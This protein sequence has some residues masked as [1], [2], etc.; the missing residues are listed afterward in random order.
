MK[1]L[2]IDGNSIMNRAFYGI[3]MLTNKS[4]FPTNALTGFLNIYVKLLNEDKPDRIAAAFDL[5]APTFRHKLYCQYKAGRHAM[6][7]ELVRQM[8]VIKDILRGLGISI[9]ETE[10]YEAD[11]II[12]TLSAAAAAQNAECVIMT[13]D[14]DSF[15]LVNEHVTVRLASNKD[16]IYY[17][18]EKINEVYGVTPREM[19]EVKAL[20]GDSSDNIPG[21]AGI[22]EKTALSLIQRYHTIQ[23]IYEHLEELDVTKSVRAKLE[24]GKGSAELSRTL[25]EICLS[26]PISTALDD[27]KPGSGNRSEVVGILRELQMNGAIKKL[28]LEGIAPQFPLNCS[29]LTAASANSSTDAQTAVSTEENAENITSVGSVIVKDEVPYDESAIDIISINDEICAF[30]GCKKIEDDLKSILESDS[31]KHTD[32]AKALYTYCI[33][34]GIE[35]RNVTFDTTLA[36][37][38]LDVNA[39]SYEIDRLFDEYHIAY[40]PDRPNSRILAQT[41]L[42]KTLYAQI[43][44]QG[45]LKVLREIEIPLAEVLA[46]MEHEGVLLDTAALNAFGEDLLP[47]ISE[48]TENVYRLAGH[49]FNIGSPKQLSAVLFSELGLPA[50]KKKSTGYSTDS[51][52]LE[53]IADKHPIIA[54]ILEY[55]RLTKLYN[56]YV[57]GLQGAVS[58]DGRMYT[59]F[60]Q[61]ETRTGRIS[62]AEPNIQNIPV[63]TEIG[64]NFR[65]FFIAA[66]GKVL[67]DADYSQIELR[68]LASLA[69]DEVMIRTFLDNRDIHAETAESVFRKTEG[70]DP[71]DL[72]RKAKAV[73]FGIVYG[74]GPFSLAKDI[75]STL[76]DAKQYIEDYLRHFSG[77]DKYMNAI[78]KSAEADGY[79]VTYFGR[80]RFIPEILSTNKTVKALGTRIARNTP[81]QGTAADIIKLAMVKVYQRLKRE[82]PEAKLIL[83]VHDELIVE[84]PE[85]SSQKALEILKEEMQ[86]AAKLDVPLLVDAKTG[87]NWFETH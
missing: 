28:G 67:C 66:P 58:A 48:I 5:K 72:R 26:V 1:L 17:T 53:A 40:E 81:I 34:R 65:K 54:P 4:G 56:T 37:Y 75:G 49:E 35:L 47:K 11:D 71:H 69:K 18:P 59:T 29:S 42:N 85:A 46:S 23:Y 87:K 50:G 41:L 78:T 86:N 82:L 30:R 12:G 25:G 57:K 76:S 31:H 21:V 52:T 36:A 6:P 13:G 9:V 77:V 3:R 73:N 79:A 8:P 60:K 55:R 24:A 32:N 51:E 20:Q 84:V 27:Y 74:I 10:G 83:Q 44:D 43:C 64:R 61:T 15:Q 19:L 33:E 38:L 45:M 39:K 62:S 14:R 70:Q 22:G 80:R 7:D 68:V 16:D 2:L 63:R